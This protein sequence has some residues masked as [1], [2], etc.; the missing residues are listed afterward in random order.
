MVDV[1]GQLK[2]QQQIMSTSVLVVAGFAALVEAT[3]VLTT[4]PEILLVGSIILSSLT[5]ATIYASFTCF[6]IYGYF[7]NELRQNIEN[8]FPN[9]LVRQD[10]RI[11]Q[12]LSYD[13]QK[14]FRSVVK[15]ALSFGKFLVSLIP[16]IVLLVLYWHDHIGENTTFL[17]FEGFLIG[18]AVFFIALSIL[19]ALV[20]GSSLARDLR[21]RKSKR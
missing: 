9:Q 6:D 14:N 15:G 18:A 16:S 21:P 19:G 12:W 17:S 3:D 4:F 1:E 10:L 7:T 13:R 11:F 20:N 2:L 5:A 8:L